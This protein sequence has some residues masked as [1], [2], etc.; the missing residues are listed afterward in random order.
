MYIPKRYGQSKLEKCPFCGRQALIKNKQ[1]VPV[2]H[3]HKNYSLNEMKCMCGKTL[4]MRSGKW[5]IFFSCLNCG[6]L[7]LR[8]ALEINEGV[9]SAPIKTNELSTEQP[10]RSTPREITIRSDDPDYF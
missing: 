3:D 8:K 4:E 1:D 5:G 7:N 10:I 2:C 9:H 6:N